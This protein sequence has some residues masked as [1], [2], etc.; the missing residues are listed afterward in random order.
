MKKGRDKDTI[1]LGS[2][3]LYVMEFTGTLPS[4]AEVET[5]ANR[6]GY[7]RGGAS[8]EYAPEFY[9]AKDDLGYVSKVIMT[10]EEATLKAGVMTW[11]GKALD[12]LSS[13]A[14]TTEENGKRIVKIGGAG[15]QDG[16]K[17]LIHF[18]HEDKV[19]GDVRVRIVGN[20]QAGFTIAF[21]KDSETVIDAEF[22]A[23]P[24]DSEG[25]LI[26]YEEEI[27]GTVSSHTLTI[28]AD[29]GGSITTGAS[30]NYAAGAAVSIEATPESGFTFSGWTS[31]AGGTFADTSDAATT[32]TMPD[33]D[34]TITASFT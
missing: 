27:A 11:D 32:F 25:T 14:R 23:Q 22:K 17:Y 20:N 13:T 12:K 16:K 34:T 31:S 30:G 5:E 21:A 19:D 26:Y 6:Y 29:T 15:N 9:E 24:M 18:H 7:I 1:T 10:E 4:N 8:L 3:R 33:N 2:G 28:T